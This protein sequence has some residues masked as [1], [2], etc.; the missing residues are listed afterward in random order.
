MARR[1][2]RARRWVMCTHACAHACSGAHV[3]A[4]DD[5][6]KRRETNV[7]QREK[8]VDQ[9]EKRLDGAPPY[10]QARAGPVGIPVGVPRPMPDVRVPMS[11]ARM[12]ARMCRA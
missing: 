2:A 4:R 9:R 12:R 11:P 10:P 7:E 8:A 6:L 1:A 5:E 3:Q